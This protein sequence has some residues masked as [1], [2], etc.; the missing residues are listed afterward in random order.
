[1]RHIAR[2]AGVSPAVV[3]RLFRGDPELRISDQRRREIFEARDR[4]G[5][6]KVR[7][8]KLSHVI[9]S[10]VGLSQDQAYIKRNILE[11][12]T[13]RTFEQE[14]KKRG[15]RLRFEHL[16]EAEVCG[17]LKR[18]IG[19]PGRPDGMLVLW[20][21]CTPELAHMLR[22]YA[23]PHVSNDFTREHLEIN[24]VCQHATAGMRQAVE[25]LAGLGHRRIAFVG[26]TKFYR[27]PMMVSTMT[28]LDLPLNPSDNCWLE[29]VRYPQDVDELRE[30]ARDAFDGWFQRHRHVTAVVCSRDHVAL[31]VVDAM[32]RR[33][34][35][36]GR[37]LS[38]I[39]YDNLEVHRPRPG[40]KPILTT[41]D[42]P[43]ERV[44][45]RMAELLLNQILHGQTAIIHERVPV[46]LVVRETTGPC[47]G[48]PGS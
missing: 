19:S 20:N 43:F 28:A 33:G 38:V 17:R 30:R 44:G 16:P 32:K 12:R 31:G 8:S 3:S 36:P 11:D 29:P 47:L 13:Y 25:H 9:V 2:E 45:R 6:V 14:L 42:L 48:R 39:G 40:E 34:L 22:M 7:P 24:T 10:P 37:D 18:W 27:Y 15:Y 26:Q 23:F 46:S 21:Y 1:M 4:L 41:I 35:V 5:G